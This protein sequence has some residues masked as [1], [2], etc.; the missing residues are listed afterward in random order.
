MDEQG[1]QLVGVETT[2]I[3]NRAT[4]A[5]AIQAGSTNAENGLHPNLKRFNGT[6]PNWQLIDINAAREFGIA[7]LPYVK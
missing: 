1:K 2:V 7:P 6:D 3:G 4:L 5:Q